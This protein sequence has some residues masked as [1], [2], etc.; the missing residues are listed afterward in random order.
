MPI[1]SA[2]SA[3]VFLFRL[4][5]L[6]FLA[7]QPIT[8]LCEGRFGITRKEWRLILTLGRSGPLLSTQ[9]A[10]KARIVPARTSR[11]VTSLVEKGLVRRE[12][13][14]SDRRFVEI[15]LT[16]D[17]RRIF[18]EMFPVVLAID[19]ALL[20]VLRPQEREVL[21]DMLVR[22]EQRVEL[23]LVQEAL[24]KINRRRR[25]ED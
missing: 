17:G 21:Q 12:P 3:D 1:E 9:L 14:P 4:Y 19:K 24:P 15:V 6:S 20:D 10:H 8:R 5:K 22:L 23:P 16:D 13:R 18:D 7:S 2:A 25:K 11:T